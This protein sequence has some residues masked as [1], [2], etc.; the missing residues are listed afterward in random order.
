MKTVKR[1]ISKACILKKISLD[2]IKTRHFPWMV[3]IVL[4]VF[5][6]L[7]ILLYW[8]KEI[9]LGSLVLWVLQLV[10]IG[11]LFIFGVRIGQRDAFVDGFR[12]GRDGVEKKN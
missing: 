4:I 3:A 2:D 6:T 1:K 7:G 12:N 11:L 10:V 8:Q 9:T 5:L